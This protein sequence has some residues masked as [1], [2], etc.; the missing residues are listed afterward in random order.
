MII[1][2][3]SEQNKSLQ[4]LDKV[5]RGG[6]PPTK[7]MSPSSNVEIIEEFDRCSDIECP[8]FVP[9]ILWPGKGMLDIYTYI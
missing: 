5:V 8:R 9:C 2:R 1:E 4:K 3:V 7:K 6:R